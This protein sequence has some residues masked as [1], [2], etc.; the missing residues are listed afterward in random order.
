MPDEVKPKVE[1]KRKTRA[2]NPATPADR[3]TSYEEDIVVIKK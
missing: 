2:S 1:P 3:F